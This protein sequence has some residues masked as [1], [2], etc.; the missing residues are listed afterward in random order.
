MID[1]N[2]SRAKLFD[3]RNIMA[4]N[5][6]SS[7]E[8]C[9]PDKINLS[10]SAHSGDCGLCF[11]CFAQSSYAM[12]AEPSGSPGC[13]ELAFCTASAAR[14]RIALTDIVSILFILFSS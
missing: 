14:T 10:L 3:I 2:N 4:R 5:E 13:P 7:V 1:K 6:Y 8:P 11:M 9:P 12:A